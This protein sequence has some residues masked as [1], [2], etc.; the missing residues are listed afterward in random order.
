MGS[1]KLSVLPEPVPVVTTRFSPCPLSAWLFPDA[2]KEACPALARALFLQQA[3]AFQTRHSL[4]VLGSIPAMYALFHRSRQ[5]QEMARWLPYRP[6]AT[7][8]EILAQY[9]Q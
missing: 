7:L 9:I 8:S 1:K 6:S 3:P 2:D 4:F 5:Y